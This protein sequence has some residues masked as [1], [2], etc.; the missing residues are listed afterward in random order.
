[1]LRGMMR[2]SRFGSLGASAA[3]LALLLPALACGASSPKDPPQDPLA[4]ELGRAK[5]LLDSKSGGALAGAKQAVRPVLARAEGDLREGRRQLALQ[6][7]VNARE[8]LAIATYLSGRTAAQS[9][10]MPG[11]ETEWARMGGELRGE[12]GA[13]SPTAFDGVPA[14]AR[15]LGEAAVP[16]MRGY[17]DASLD[18]GRATM[19]DQGLYYLAAAQGQ[20]AIAD[21]CRTLSASASQGTPPPVRSIRPELDALAAEMISV[22]RPP[23]SIDQHGAFIVAS[24][25]LKEARELDA[26]GLHHGALLR[27]LQAAR[28]FAPLRPASTAKAGAID[29]QLRDL[30]ARLSPS[31]TQT[32][33]DHGI[34]RLFL[35]I[36]Q[37][38]LAAAATIVNDTLP[39]YFAALEPAR[40]A[41]PRPDPQVTV[42]LVRWPYT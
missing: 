12:L 9:K 18:Y 40:P 3:L 17:Y 11:F 37:T 26:A 39:R 30:E 8:S 38:E 21:F 41:A 24:S 42:T 4:V 20:R 31:S 29:Q 27:Y 2:D 6:R 10:D 36:A 32:G 14:A 7:L 19:P 35:E 23:V 22:Y 25:T 1:M 34:G 28:Q 16:Q 13:P 5:A 15:A 33:I